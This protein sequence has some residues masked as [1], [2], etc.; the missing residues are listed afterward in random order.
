MQI[1]IPRLGYGDV[2]DPRSLAGLQ[3]YYDAYSNASAAYLSAVPTLTDLGPNGWDA[4]QSVGGSQAKMLPWTGEN[5]WHGPGVSGNNITTPGNAANNYTDQLEIIMRIDPI[6][7]APSAANQYL[8]G[9]WTG[10]ASPPTNRRWAVQIGGTVPLNRIRLVFGDGTTTQQAFSDEYALSGTR[11]IRIQYIKDT[12]AGQYSV[13]FFSAPDGPTVPT[14]WTSMGVRTGTSIG[15]FTSGGPL[16]L[17]SAFS[18]TNPR[19]G[20]YYYASFGR[21]FGT[22]EQIF[23]ASRGNSNSDTIT[24]ETGEVWTINRSGA[25]PARI[26]SAPAWLLDGTQTFY[27]LPSAALGMLRNVPGATVVAVAALSST[28]ATNNALVSINNNSTAARAVIVRLTATNRLVAGGRRLD[29]DSFASIAAP[30]APALNQALVIGGR[31]AYSAAQASYFENGASVADSAFQTPG[32]TSDTNSF[33]IR[34]GT[35][36]DTLNPQFW[37]GTIERLAIYNRA[38]SDA[39]IRALSRYFALRSRAGITV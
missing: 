27:P 13:A 2:S 10:A 38:L 20:Q 14:A 23:D 11:W 6:D 39:E 16:E 32:N 24:S 3:A 21:V 22:P 18:G 15:D 7:W 31:L 17:G 34:I 19:A 26:V 33:A 25:N 8:C 35:G 5:Y 1:I 30:A 4:T 28:P 9:K 12:G 29:A 36:T 37:P